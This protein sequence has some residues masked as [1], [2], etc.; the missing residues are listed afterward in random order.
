[1]GISLDLSITK[2]DIV[3]F[4][5][6]RPGYLPYGWRKLRLQQDL[7]TIRDVFTMGGGFDLH[8]VEH[9]MDDGINY[10]VTFAVPKRF[11]RRG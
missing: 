4:A 1:M 7:H 9:S 8:A 5:T 6:F 11:D 2:Y 10:D 3:R